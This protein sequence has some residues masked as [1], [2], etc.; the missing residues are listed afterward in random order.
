M[1]FRNNDTDKVSV[2]SVSSRD[3][4]RMRVT[5]KQLLTFDAVARC[6]SIG[7]A[8]Q[9][10]CLSQSAVSVTIKDLESALDVQLFERNRRKLYLNE[11]GRRLQL[12]ARAILAHTRELENE[13]GGFSHSGILRVACSTASGLSLLPKVCAAFL[14]TYPAVDLKLATMSSSAVIDQIETMQQDVGVI[15]APSM[16]TS[17]TVLPW[18]DDNLTLFCAPQHPLAGRE[19][20]PEELREERWAVQPL[21]SFTR[22][23]VNT[24][25][26]TTL[27]LSSLR[28]VFESNNITAL[29]SV[30][31]SGHALGCLPLTALEENLA[32]GD[33]T[34][35]H[36]RNHQLTRKFHIIR[37]KDLYQGDVVEAFIQLATSL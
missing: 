1:T 15:D 3:A 18:K 28:V 8:S 33:L 27:G 37:R 31:Q 25:I 24:F 2:H 35:L 23:A 19:V 11:N 5:L 16:R 10:L 12:R 21:Q 22:Y 6:G 14:N 4:M 13:L 9:E 26:G 29:K 17:L 36:V 7:A 34:V 30:V 32:L 20:S